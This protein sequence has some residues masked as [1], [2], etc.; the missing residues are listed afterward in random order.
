MFCDVQNVVIVDSIYSLGQEDINLEIR[1]RKF[2]WIDHTLRKRMEK[3]QR[4][5]YSGTLK[6]TG[7][8]ED[9]KTAG[10]DL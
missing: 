9:R 7:R 6:E 1:K 4:L 5:P 8:E 2:S 10:E 3:Y